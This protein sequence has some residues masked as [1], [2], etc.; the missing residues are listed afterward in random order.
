MKRLFWVG[1]GAAAGYYAARRGEAAVERARE[2]GLV[3]N[4]TLAAT[5]AQKAAGAATRTA[6]ALGERAR[7]MAAEQ[8]DGASAPAPT[9]LPAPAPAP[10]P[11]P[12]PA[13][14][15]AREARP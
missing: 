10:Q 13:A 12:A 2:R 11:A 8:A 4:V 14:R 6:A 5:T 3:G 1:V 15:D 7:A 9:P